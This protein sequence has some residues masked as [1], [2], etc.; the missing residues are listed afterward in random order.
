MRPMRVFSLGNLVVS[1]FLCASC[2]GATPP[3]SSPN[4]ASSSDKAAT[5]PSSSEDTAPDETMA[6]SE[7]ESAEGSDEAGGDE[8]AGEEENADVPRAI[9]RDPGEETR[10]LKVVQ[11]IIRQNRQLVRDC[12]EKALSKNKSLQGDLTI[13]FVIGPNGDVKTA[14]LNR[15]RSTL[16]DPAVVQCS[17]AAL[18][19]LKFPP[20]SKGFE[21]KVNYP[22]NLNP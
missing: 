14:E 9:K 5:E 11:Q 3:A 18:K 2:G 12:Y 10:T 21:S 22:F 16:T 20:S 8:A 17:V 19:T 13:H 6:T 15:E 1:V 7:G 4:E